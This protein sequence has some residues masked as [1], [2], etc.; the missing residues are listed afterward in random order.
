MAHLPKIA[1]IYAS[2][3]GR[4]RLMAES[5]AE[6]ARTVEG[7]DILIKDVSY[8]TPSD[9]ADAKV[10]L[11]GGSTYSHQLIPSMEPFLKEMEKLDLKS[12]VG[13]AFGS[14]GWSG[15]GVPTLMKRMKSFGMNMI[16]PGFTA[17]QEPNDEVIRKC[18]MLGKTVAEGIKE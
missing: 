14:Y 8:A 7:I 17:K 10:I 12:K 11:L 2:S 18:F 1:I 9:V 5:I 15:E 13:V 16:E 3:L 4:T 6:G